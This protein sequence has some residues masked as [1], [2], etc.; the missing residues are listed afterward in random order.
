MAMALAAT[1]ASA[2]GEALYGDQ[3]RASLTATGSY[4]DNFYYNATKIDAAGA[5]L[6]PEVQFVTETGKAQIDLTGRGE[7]GTFDT[8][9]SNDD[10][11]DSYGQARFGWAPTYRN[12]LLLEGSYTHGHDP[13]GLVRTEGS[14][15]VN[16]EM[17]EWDQSS[18]TMRYR[19]GA[20][21]AT[22]NAEVSG[23][24]TDRSYATNEALTRFLDYR[25]TQID[26]SVFYNYSP[27]TAAVVS[28]TRTDVDVRQPFNN[29]AGPATAQ[30]PG[31]SD[32]DD[33]S[34]ETYQVRAGLRW[35]ATA[36][37]SGD[38]RAGYRQRTF[39]DV[40][41]D[42]EGFDW[43]AGIQWSPTQP[44]LFE[45]RTARSE[46]QSYLQNAG[47]IDIKTTTLRAKRSLSSRLRGEI[48]LEQQ[49]ADFF[50]T[51]R[52]DETDSAT[53]GLEYVAMSY[54]FV[55]G[56]VGYQ[57]RESSFAGR[58]YDRFNAFVG[59]RLGR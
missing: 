24:Y 13:F 26:Y 5:V 39:D 8:P 22:V 16:N 4:T 9:G 52:D 21:A 49:L 44:M 54:L 32:V 18:G 37:T 35:L 47:V 45:L 7:Y 27:K 33:R 25:T 34:G 53:V 46:Q 12:R 57:T 41:A 17:D 3:L 2:D 19:Y 50:G 30:D 29:N 56:N 10:Y 14:A 58:D 28:F 42:L 40:A 23:T 20:P 38:V 31:G 48:A 36:K 59:L 43:Q 55:V 6:R 11:L 15:T 51:G 1:A